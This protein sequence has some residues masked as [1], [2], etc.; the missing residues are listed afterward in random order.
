MAKRLGANRQVRSEK[1][2]WW[3]ILRTLML[4][5]GR[6]K[7][8]EVEHFWGIIAKWGAESS[9]G[10]VSW[11]RNVQDGEGYQTSWRWKLWGPNVHARTEK[12]S[13][14]E[15]SKWRGSET[16]QGRNVYQV[17]RAKSPVTFAI[18]LIIENYWRIMAYLNAIKAYSLTTSVSIRRFPGLGEDISDDQQKTI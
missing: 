15:T 8:L 11:G 18:Y 7:R 3:R 2:W 13:A 14:G 4:K 5:R 6:G 9:E 1:F 12:R 10:Q 17:G 16:F